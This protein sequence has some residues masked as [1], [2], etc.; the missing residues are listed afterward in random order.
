MKTVKRHSLAE[1]AQLI[2]GRLSGEPSIDISGVARLD[3]ARAGNLT[4]VGAPKYL[5]KWEESTASA[6]IVYPDF[7]ETTRNVIRV[8][9][10][11][12]AFYKAA[13]FFHKHREALQPGIHPTAV[14]GS[15]TFIG[16]NCS[17]GPLVT[18]G[19]ECE[20]GNAVKIYPGA[21][22]GDGVSI[23]D[24]TIIYQNVSIREDCAIGRNAIIHCGVVI[25]SD[26]FGF[27]KENGVYKKIPQLGNVVIEDD[28]EIGANCTIDRAVVGSTR[29]CKGTKLDNL[30]QV[31]HN[32]VIGENTVIAAQTGISGSTKIG[33]NVMMGGQVG[34]NGHIEIG[35][36][37]ILAA[38]CGVTK[39]VPPKTMISGYPARNHSR[40]KR[41]EAIIRK[42][43]ELYK[44]IRKLQKQ[45]EQLTKQG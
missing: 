29:I 45:V 4:F 10:P 40:A 9:Q 33:K 13:M 38:Q 39:S 8:E 17:I 3:E 2:K 26:G 15:D 28:V 14:V 5:K 20:I 34:L 24:D 31:A 35:D 27:D 19:S 25:G 22:V 43:P 7:P 16:E 6:F 30:I 23:G 21:V 18:I 42:L 1:I 41:E 37:A 11:V 36:Y 12:Q 44:E 32:V